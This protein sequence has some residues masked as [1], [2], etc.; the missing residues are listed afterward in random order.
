MWI[1]SRCTC[2]PT[3]SGIGVARESQR[4]TLAHAIALAQYR[5]NTRHIH[6]KVA[7]S[8]SPGV[9]HP[10]VIRVSIA[11][12]GRHSAQAPVRHRPGLLEIGNHPQILAPVVIQPGLVYYHAQIGV[13]VI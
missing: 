10:Q 8:H 9:F 13:L 5:I 2:R 3:M 4:L 1:T 7:C 6:V 11:S 12:G